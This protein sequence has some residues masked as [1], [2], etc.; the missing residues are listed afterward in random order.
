[1]I[2]RG[3]ERRPWLLGTC[4]LAACFTDGGLQT[5]QASGIDAS[6]GT[7]TTDAPATGSTTGASTSTAA[8]DDPPPTCGNDLIEAP[9]EECD[10]GNAD[11]DDACPSN[12]KIAT[13]GDGFVWAGMEECDDGP[14][15]SDAPGATCRTDCTSPPACG[16]GG[17]YVGPLGPPISLAGINNQPTQGNDAP[18]SIGVDGSNQFSVVWRTD[19]ASDQVPVQR[20]GADGTLLGQPLNYQTQQASDVVDPAIAVAP[21]GDTAV[22]WERGN[23]VVLA[24]RVGDTQPPVALVTPSMTGTFLSP[25]VGMGPAGQAAVAVLGD[26]GDNTLAVFVRLFPDLGTLA[27][28]PPEQMVSDHL[29][30]DATPPTVAFDPTGA[31]LVA[32]GDPGG[33]ILYRRY[34]ASGQPEA[35]VTSDLRIGSP[36]SNIFSPWTGATLQAHDSSAVLAGLD[37]DGHLALQRFDTA[38]TAQPPVQVD[39]QDPRFVQ[40]VDVVSD[41]WGNLAVAW[42]ACGTPQ[43]LGATNCNNLVQRW[44]IRWFFADLDPLRPSETLFEGGFGAIAPVS[45]AIG[46]SGVTAVT[47]VE[48]NEPKVRI[49]QLVCP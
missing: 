14:D 43:D 29:T 38:D 23:S 21:N 30:D 28:A 10:D 17:L 1:M 48:N 7:S 45:V 5:S 42:N 22:V 24:T 49:A 41:P 9:L 2:A 20:I 16:D 33:H 35:I 31:F 19:G 15:N 27:Q 39:E 11:D 34:D 4:L 12:C 6:S 47:Y 46:P 13:C 32:W 8:T 36:D 37:P 25:S 44:K 3:F 18:R 26:T 40:F